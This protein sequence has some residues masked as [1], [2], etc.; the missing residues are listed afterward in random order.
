MNLKA[1]K[2]SIMSDEASR[3]GRQNASH[4]QGPDRSEVCLNAA[5]RSSILDDDLCFEQ[6]V[7][8]LDR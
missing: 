5:A 6:R 3:Q 2:E 8:L 4:G 7:E 1:A